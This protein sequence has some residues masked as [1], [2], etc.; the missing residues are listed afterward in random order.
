MLPPG[1]PWVP[2]KYISKFGSAV[3][4]ALANIHL[5][6]YYIFAN[7]LNSFGEILFLAKFCWKEIF[8]AIW[9]QVLSSY[10]YLSL[11]HI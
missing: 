10:Y 6:T 11:I 3:G 2:S 1:Y 9:A 5:Y 8:L 7:I 4:L